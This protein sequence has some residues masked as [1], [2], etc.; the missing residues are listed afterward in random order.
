[1]DAVDINNK[2]LISQLPGDIISVDATVSEEYQADYEIIKAVYVVPAADGSSNSGSSGQSNRATIELT[3]LQYL[4]AAFSDTSSVTLSLRAS[5][6]SGLAPLAQ[7]DSLGVQRL[8]STKQNN[9][10][11][12]ASYFTGGNP[13][14]QSGSSST[15]LVSSFTIQYGFGQVSYNSGSVNPG[16]LGTW[17]VYTR[18]P[19]FTGGAVTYFA[20]LST[21]QSTLTSFDDVVCVGT[22]VLT[23]GGGAH[24]TGGGGGACFSGNVKVRVPGGLALLE[25]LDPVCVI[26]TEFGP[27]MADVI[28]TE[29]SGEM[30]DMGDRQLVTPGHLIQAGPGW[31]PASMRWERVVC[32]EGKVYTLRVH[33]EI[34]EERHFILE[35]GTKAH[36]I[37]PP[38]Q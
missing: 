26:T 12:V 24:G 5:I 1:M 14:S 28:V 35:D 13:L 36:N 9:P 30:R 23:G 8:A 21:S 6:T 34:D 22:I 32:F 3:L 29:Y 33:T 15:I 18:D 20:V 17:T 10:T 4:A 37:S 7:V 38:P 27:R 31:L 19:Q 11:N 25:G 16:S 2:A